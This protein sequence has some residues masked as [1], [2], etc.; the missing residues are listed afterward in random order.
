MR[1]V[2]ET[3][4]RIPYQSG[5]TDSHGNPVESWGVPV[6]VG[7][8]GFD[9]GATGEPRRPGFDRVTVDPTVY[10]PYEM[11]FEYRDKAVVRGEVFTV[12]GVVRRW[13]HPNGKEP[14]A[15][16]HLQRVEG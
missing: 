7:I 5:A 2:S 9:P 13:R 10:G 6:D 11:P 12:E 3:V 1:R 4:Q 15:V 8:Y 16:V 14:G